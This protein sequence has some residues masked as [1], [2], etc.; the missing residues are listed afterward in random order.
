MYVCQVVELHGTE[1]AVA[2][3]GVPLAEGGARRPWFFNDSATP[4]AAIASTPTA[5]GATLH[6]HAAGAQMGGFT[7]SYA[8]AT[9]T[10]GGGGGATATSLSFVTFKGS[11]HM[12][13]AYA[14]QRA[15]HVLHR[16]LL[17]H[18]AGQP[19]IQL[20]P[21]LPRDWDSASDAEF[22]AR[23]G[24]GSPGLF[25]QWIAKATGAPYV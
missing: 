25:A 17:G 21:P 16:L 19:R 4:L 15:L 8:A 20:A 5:W 14:P 3:I 22:Y 10:G 13:A 1:A 9:A 18:A 11:G 2:K 6:A 7:T 23:G 24:S 12:V